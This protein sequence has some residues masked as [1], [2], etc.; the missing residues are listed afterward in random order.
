M[1]G[2]LAGQLDRGTG[3]RL[4]FKIIGILIRENNVPAY[5]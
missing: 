2:Y 1:V 3:G 5:F 4:A